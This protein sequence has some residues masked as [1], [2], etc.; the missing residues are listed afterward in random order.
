MRKVKQATGCWFF[1][2]VLLLA[3]S[4]SVNT[5]PDEGGVSDGDALDGDEDLPPITDG[6]T[7]ESDGD[8]LYPLDGDT[9]IEEEGE[10][11]QDRDGD[12]DGDGEDGDARDCIRDYR[13]GTVGMIMNDGRAFEGY[14]L[15]APL[16]SDITYL[17]DTCGER[18]HSWDCGLR[19]GHAV[20]LLENGKLLQ[21]ANP[22]PNTN[23]VFGGGG[24]GGII[25]LF[26]FDGTL[27]W[28]FQYSNEEHRLHH[29]VEM[30]PNGNILAITWEYKSAAEAV[31]AG[32][33]PNYLLSGSLW[34]DALIEID[35]S[36]ADGEEIV[37]EWH[38]WD[39][40]V[41]DYDEEKGNYATVADHP[42]LL[43]INYLI[44]PNR[45]N[46]Q[47]D[48]NH[49]NAVD[50]NSDLDQIAISLH[51]MG[52]IFIIEHSESSVIAAGHTGGRYGKGGDIL[53]R[54]GNPQVYGAGGAQDQQL[55]GQH[56]IQWIEEGLPGEGNLLIF[57]NGMGRIGASYSTVEEISPPIQADG[58]YA[59]QVGT[60]YA[61]E[62]ALWIYKEDPV[63]DFYSQN[64]SGAQRLANGNT[65]IC[66]GATG[67][68]F[69]VTSEGERVWE[70]VNPVTQ[71]GPVRQGDVPPSMNGNQQNNVFRAYRYAPNYP[72]LEG[73]DL[74]PKGVIELPAE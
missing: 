65:L 53:D 74:E 64:I 29:D 8:Y 6:D 39:H 12:Q 63:S 13:L 59:L 24:E 55:F 23:P 10:N 43:D 56:D 3:L 2:L 25:Q 28:S 32:R 4:C 11:D 71:N 18:V 38:I 41:Q 44:N 1:V 16:A 37:W 48:W 45:P 19:P 47:N 30:M 36:K 26:A 42:E 9:E 73:R 72:G 46:G 70:Y 57:N 7:L 20:Y 40:L 52:E 21:T 68:L 5:E 27:E 61:P 15:F 60:A 17:I 33:N 62:Q 22:G 58:S 35:P 66:E 69:E 50:Y 31:E 54:W 34:P 49:T 14:T 51:N 67:R